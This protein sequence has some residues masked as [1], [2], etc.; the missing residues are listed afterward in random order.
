[1]AQC[2]PDIRSIGSG[3]SCS[4]DTARRSINELIERGIIFK[5]NFGNVGSR[6]RNHYYFYWD[7][8]RLSEMYEHD[9]HEMSK[10][11]EYDYV[12]EV[13]SR[14]QRYLN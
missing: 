14:N 11:S 3:A 13:L 7:M 6:T 9:N 12:E 4:T 1:M 2:N 8:Y 5:I 10:T